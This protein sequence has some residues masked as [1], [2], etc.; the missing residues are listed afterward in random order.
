MVSH[1]DALP[2]RDSGSWAKHKLFAWHRYLDIVTTAMVDKPQWKTGVSYVDLFAG[3]GVCTIRPS[4]ERIPGSPF[5]A[6]HTSKPLSRIL[7]CELDPG[8]A[9]TCKKRMDAGP[10]RHRYHF[11]NGD[12][13]VEIDRIIKELPKGSLTLAFLDPTGLHLHFETVSKLSEHGPVDLLILF[14][15]AIDILR[16]AEHYYFDRTDSNLDLVLGEGSDWRRKKAALTSNEGSV[17]RKLFLEIYKSQLERIAGYKYFDD[18]VIKGPSG[19]LYRL[20][21]ATKHQVAL[22]FWNKSVKKELSGQQRLF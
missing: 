6:A 13:N 12:C 22:D 11:F 10:A 4:G 7:L 2:V 17:V 9:A 21:F 18:L 14:P 15:D 1:D 16:N 3:P 8:L 20:V 19:P 5:I